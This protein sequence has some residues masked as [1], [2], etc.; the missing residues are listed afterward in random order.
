VEDNAFCFDH[1]LL[2]ASERRTICHSPQSRSGP[3]PGTDYTC[4]FVVRD[5][6]HRPHGEFSDA[7]SHSSIISHSGSKLM[8]RRNVRQKGLLASNLS[9][10]SLGYRSIHVSSNFLLIYA[11]RQEP[12]PM[13]YCS[14]G[15]ACMDG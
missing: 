11:I 5:V 7:G 9:G 4:S 2:W 15:F 10:P 12:A 1:H 13:I 6:P 14:A 3:A 8:V